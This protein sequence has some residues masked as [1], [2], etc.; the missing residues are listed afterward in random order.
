MK[1]RKIIF[2]DIDGTFTVPLEKPTPLAI[3][4]VRTARKNGH[5]V[6]LCTG[7]NM[8]IISQDILEVGFDGIVASAGSHIEVEENVRNP[9]PDSEG[10][11]CDDNVTSRWLNSM[12]N[13]S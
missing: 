2:L 1:N 10:C 12:D 9:L 13:A 3:E 11:K 4:A 7:R 5:K 8:P 6:F